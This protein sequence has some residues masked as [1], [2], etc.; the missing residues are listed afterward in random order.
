M[1]EIKNSDNSL[2]IEDCFRLFL[3][4]LSTLPEKLSQ[5]WPK[6]SL[7]KRMLCILKPFSQPL[8][9]NLIETFGNFL[10]LDIQ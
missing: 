2:I 5:T 1:L 4:K 10:T 6:R 7:D 9:V 3:H 8:V